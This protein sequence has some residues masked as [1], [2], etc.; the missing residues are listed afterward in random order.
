MTKERTKRLGG[1]RKWR[2]KHLLPACSAELQLRDGSIAVLV[3]PRV[4][5][6]GDIE[7]RLHP[8]VVLPVGAV[9]GAVE[10]EE[11]IALLDCIQTDQN[12]LVSH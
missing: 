1:S 6:G 7:I 10:A 11:E 3:D 4:S 9:A 5:V 12:D 2:S 8:G